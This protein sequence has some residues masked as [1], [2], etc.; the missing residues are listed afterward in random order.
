MSDLFTKITAIATLEQGWT[1]VKGNQGG[2]GG[3]RMTLNQFEVNR[4]RRIA[5]LHRALISGEYWPAPLRVV[6]IP[7][8]SGGRRVLSIPSVIDRVA[9]SAASLILTP[10][11]DAEFEDASFGYRPGRS[12]QMAVAR[13]AT[14][15]RQGYG[16]TVD[17]DIEA[18]FDNV[19]HRRLLARLERSVDCA[20]TIDLVARWLEAY[21]ET[22]RGLP[23]GGPISPL[24]SN[25]YLDD[26]DEGLDGKG[27]RLVRF[28]DDFLIMCNSE[29]AAAQAHDKVARLLKEAG[30]RL[31]PEKTRITRFEEATRFL[32]HLFVRGMAMP[33]EY[34]EFLEPSEEPTPPAAAE[35]ADADISDGPRD[36]LRWV[37][38]T[39][40]GRVLDHRN[41]SLV[42]RDGADGPELSAIPPGWADAIELGGDC[43]ATDPALRL[44]LSQ[45]TPV[46]FLDG[47]GEMLGAACPPV[48]DRAELHLDQARHALDTDKCTAIAQI[49]VAARLENQRAQLYRH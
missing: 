9:Q 14:L 7:K 6:E 31:N 21:S 46:Y 10:L 44:A 43:P 16:W 24:L 3:D 27:M 48:S 12:V 39:T 17:G 30:L 22:E 38:V 18:Y 23:Q 40:P 4:D 34:E 36:R 37:Y 32:G 42:I 35:P 49:L 47:S 29:L 15:R 8:K 11:L 1:K 45:G 26:I 2:A 5:T 41:Q 13:V 28:A 19:P 33:S 25:L 20:K